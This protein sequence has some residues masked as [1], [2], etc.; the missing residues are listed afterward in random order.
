MEISTFTHTKRLLKLIIRERERVEENPY[1]IFSGKIKIER[2]WRG[3]KRKS[4][5]A[6]KGP[7]VADSQSFYIF[8]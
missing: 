5:K 4:D 7:T 2:H 1:N 3:Y 8:I 6:T